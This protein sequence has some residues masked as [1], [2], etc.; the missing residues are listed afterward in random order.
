MATNQKINTILTKYLTGKLNT[1]EQEILNSWLSSSEEN[2]KEFDTYI[3]LW[4]KSHGLSISKKIDIEYSLRKTKKEIPG[5]QS[6]KRWIVYLRQAAAVLLLSVSFSF[7]YQ[8]FSKPA[9]VVNLPEQTIYQEVKA[10]FGTQT[11]LVLADGTSV[12]LN[13][14]SSLRFPASFKNQNERKVELNG[15]GYFEVTKNKTKPFIVNT[16]ALDVKVYGTSF[17]VSAY[18][19]YNAETVA[20][21][22][23]K[24]SLI[25]NFKGE[26]KELMVLHPNEAVEFNRTNKKLFHDTNI[27]VEKYIGWKDGFIVLYDD[28]I[29]QVIQKLEKWYNVDIVIKDQSLNNYRFTATFIDESLEQVLKLLSLSSPMSYKIIAAEKQSNNSFSKRKIILSRK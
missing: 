18:Q 1:E 6:K 7:L 8:Y 29:K 15:E 13:S 17:N 11:K 26:Q 27:H 14:G 10:A 19:G 20:L 12:W 22:E 9:E 24:I 21:V 23:G 25:N 28:P 3:K 4:E 16:C 5:F 2:Q